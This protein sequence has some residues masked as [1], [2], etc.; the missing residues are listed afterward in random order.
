M[1]TKSSMGINIIPPPMPNRPD[2][3]PPKPP[4]NSSNTISIILNSN[5]CIKSTKIGFYGKGYFFLFLDR[6]WVL[7]YFFLF[8]FE[9][10]EA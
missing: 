7:K 4:A 6:K 10:A 9:R 5:S 1:K 8:P 2:M 3:K